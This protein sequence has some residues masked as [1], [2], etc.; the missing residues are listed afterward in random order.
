VDCKPPA[1]WKFI[2][3]CDFT[4]SE[5]QLGLFKHIDQSRPLQ[6][7]LSKDLTREPTP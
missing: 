1:Q 6:T 4:V 2:L 7:R 5:A 3:G